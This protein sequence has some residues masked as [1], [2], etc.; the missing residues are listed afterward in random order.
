MV[1]LCGPSASDL[2]DLSSYRFWPKIAKCM[3]DITAHACQ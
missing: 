1:G 3:W 2:R